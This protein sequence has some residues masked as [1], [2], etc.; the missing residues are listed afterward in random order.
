MR[1]RG[2]HRPATQRRRSAVTLLVNWGVLFALVAAVVAYRGYKSERARSPLPAPQATLTETQ[3]ADWMS[4][5]RYNDVIPVLLYHSVG[6]PADYLSVPQRLFAQQMLALHLGGFNAVTLEQYLGWLHGSEAMPQNPILITFDDGALSSYRG[7]DAILARY[8][9]RATMFVVPAWLLTHPSWALQ[10]DEL[11][12][13]QDSGRWE[14]QEHAGAGHTHIKINGAGTEGEFYAYRR[15]LP[16]TAET[17]AHLESF[18]A[19]QERVTS[20]VAWGGAQL[21]SHL[22]GYQPLAFAVPYSNYGDRATNDE[23]IPAFFL[24]MLH[25]TFPLVFSGD[26]LDTGPNRPH[27]IRARFSR[28]L[29]YRI[30]QGPIMTVDQ[31]Y[32]RLHNFVLRV[33]LQDEY[34]CLSR[35]QIPADTAGG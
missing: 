26:Y 34:Q 13:M 11:Q 19:Y 10:W 27:E 21:R 9:Y 24:Q 16:A 7:A 12:A 29:S 15:Y 32:C 14:I 4:F 3:R 5:P 31:L 8:G 18:Q 20:D 28:R 1:L 6:G 23:R 2:K 35:A 33:P 25:R 17:S 22:S 30:Q